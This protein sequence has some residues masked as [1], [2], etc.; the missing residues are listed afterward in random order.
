MLLSL[1]AVQTASAEWS[2]VDIGS[3]ASINAASNPQANSMWIGDNEGNVWGSSDAGQ[4]WS[5]LTTFDWANLTGIDFGDDLFGTACTE[6]GMIYTTS[7]GGTTWT[8]AFEMWG[9]FFDVYTMPGTNSSWVGG[10]NTVMQPFVYWTYDGW[11]NQ[12]GWFF[13]YDIDNVWYEGYVRGITAFTQNDLVSVGNTWLWDGAIATSSDGGFNWTTTWVGYGNTVWDIAHSADGTAIAVTDDGS[14]LRSTDSGTTWSVVHAG[15]GTA[16]RGVAAVGTDVFWVVGDNGT[17]MTSADGGVTWTTEDSGTVS[18]LR[19]VSFA[20]ETEGVAVGEN[21]TVLVYSGVVP[22][23]ATL[24]LTPVVDFVGPDGGDIVYDAHLLSTIGATM[25]GLRYQTFVTMPDGTPAPTNPVDDIPF[26]HTPFMDV[27]V[28]GMTLTVPAIAPIGDYWL[29]AIA[30][31]PGNPALQASDS[32]MFV[33]TFFA[34]GADGGDEWVGNGSFSAGEETNAVAL[35]SEYAMGDVYPNP[36]NPTTT[37]T[38][39]LPAASELN[40]RVVNVLGQEVA[41]LV[42]GQVNAGTHSFVFDGANLA[43]G[44]YFVHAVVPGEMNAIQKITLMK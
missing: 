32:F 10:R 19:G 5:V 12:D 43:S 42:D 27:T 13:Y 26:T 20:N 21:G 11:V 14:I 35:P 6:F 28:L 7:D 3:F 33:K 16:F 34:G 1:F 40:L 39:S 30:G 38:L 44:V 2:S 18:N 36:F 25:P 22:D 15:A 23:P 37:I 17:I 31:V 4:T 41:S 9:Y 29:E 8:T 24:T